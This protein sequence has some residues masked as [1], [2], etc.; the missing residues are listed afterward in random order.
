MKM[1]ATPRKAVAAGIAKVVK[2]LHYPPDVMLVVMRWYVA[3]S[4]SLR[5]L[6]E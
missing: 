6:E 4:L 3:Y 2:Q 5:Y 1:T